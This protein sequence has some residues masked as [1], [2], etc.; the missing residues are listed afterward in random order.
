MRRPAP[1]RSAP[2]VPAAR[3]PAFAVISG[4]GWVLDVAI[5]LTLA[6]LGWPSGFANAVGAVCGVGFVFVGGTRRLFLA[7]HLPMARALAVYGLYNGVAIAVASLAV[8]LLAAE[9]A[10]LAAE[11][12][13]VALTLAGERLAASVSPDVVAAMA[14]TGVAKALVT[15]ATLYGNFLFMGWLMEGRASWW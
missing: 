3:L 5:T 6:G 13:A 11:G 12:A 8:G 15:P 1:A 4:L 2:S 7:R 9:L 14:A 10:P